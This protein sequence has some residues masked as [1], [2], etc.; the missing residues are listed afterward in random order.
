MRFRE[1]C[2]NPALSSGHVAPKFGLWFGPLVLRGDFDSVE[3]DVQFVD[4]SVNET[5]IKGLDITFNI[6]H[7]ERV[8]DGRGQRMVNCFDGSPIRLRPLYSGSVMGPTPFV[9]KVPQMIHL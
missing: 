4:L 6:E 2:R 9:G 1:A 8:I 7:V 5:N 3:E